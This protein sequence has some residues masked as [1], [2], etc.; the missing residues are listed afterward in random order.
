[1]C[2][3]SA[4]E[5]AR[6][7]SSDARKVMAVIEK[8]WSFLTEMGYERSDFLPNSQGSQSL[9]FRSIERNRRVLVSLVRRKTDGDLAL[10]VSVWKENITN[11]RE[12]MI[13]LSDYVWNTFGEKA[14][15]DLGT[16][17]WEE[18]LRY[19]TA[20]LRGTMSNVVLGEAWLSGH[21]TEPADGKN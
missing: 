3:A 2:S 19:Y 5:E 15:R 7:N 16:I 8:E 13:G 6:V 10:T 21:Q 18:Q 14:Y 9:S 12:R 11:E 4:S 20:L 17:P 1:M